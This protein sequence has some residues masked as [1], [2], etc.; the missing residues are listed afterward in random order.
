VQGEYIACR[1]Q[2]LARSR[3]PTWASFLE[4]ISGPFLQCHFRLVLVDSTYG[5]EEHGNPFF[6]TQN[7]KTTACLPSAFPLPSSLLPVRPD[8]HSFCPIPL[9]LSRSSGGRLIH[10]HGEAKITAEELLARTESNGYRKGAHGEK[11][12]T[13]DGNKHMDKARKNQDAGLVC[14]VL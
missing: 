13:Q 7:M 8:H 12:S 1:A 9:R 14:Y 4:P 11:D 6:H 10:H 2:V 3:V 5:L